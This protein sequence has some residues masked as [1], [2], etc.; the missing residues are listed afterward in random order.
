[1][2]EQVFTVTLKFTYY[3]LQKMQAGGACQTA[4]GTITRITRCAEMSSNPRWNQWWRSPLFC[5]SLDTH[6]RS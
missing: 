3:K 5:T 6:C 1:M 4:R 2:N